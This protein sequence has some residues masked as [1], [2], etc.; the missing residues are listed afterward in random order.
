MELGPRTGTALDAEDR[1]LRWLRECMD[2]VCRER[3]METFMVTSE[4]C[5]R[6]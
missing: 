5:Q 6:M 4:H 1:P 3:N 2:K